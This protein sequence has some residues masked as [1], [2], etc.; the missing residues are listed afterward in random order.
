M[1]PA[2]TQVDQKFL[3]LMLKCTDRISTSWLKDLSFKAWYVANG[4][5]NSHSKV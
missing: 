1:W 3:I 5:E 4:T 2:G